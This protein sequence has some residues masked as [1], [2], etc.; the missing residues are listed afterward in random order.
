MIESIPEFQTFLLLQRLQWTL[1]KV[2]YLKNTQNHCLDIFFDQA[3]RNIR[4][5]HSE[6]SLGYERAFNQR[7]QE[8]KRTKLIQSTVPTYCRG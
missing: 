1:S 4:T 2:N 5:S 6:I 3:D 8:I 7:L